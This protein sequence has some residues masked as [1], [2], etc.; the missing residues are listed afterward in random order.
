MDLCLISFQMVSFATKKRALIF[1]SIL[2]RGSF[3]VA[4][5]HEL[6]EVNDQTH[7]S[8]SYHNKLRPYH[9]I[10]FRVLVSS[11]FGF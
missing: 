11:L 6:T 2:L 4:L 1:N 9:S 8:S 3:D 7:G 10:L 5:R